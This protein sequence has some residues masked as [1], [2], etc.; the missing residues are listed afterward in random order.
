M[1]KDNG[2]RPQDA[3]LQAIRELSSLAR[4]KG[5]GNTDFGTMH[6]VRVTIS[7]SVICRAYAEELY[8][9]M[10]ATLVINSGNPD[11]TIPFTIQ[12]LYIYLTIILRE[13]IKDV[14]KERTLFSRSDQ[15]VKIPHFYFL[16]L[17]E[18][19]DVVDEQRHVWLQ[20][21]FDSSELDEVYEVWESTYD[22][23]RDTGRRKQ[24]NLDALSAWKE[25]YHV[26]LGEE[27]EKA[28]VYNMSRNLKL[29]ERWGFVNGSALPRGLT[30]E[31][32]FMLFMW[33][34]SK[35]VHPLPDVEPG[36]ALLASLL[37]FSRSTSLLNPYIGYGPENA[38]RILLKEVTLPRGRST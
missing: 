29:L 35:L 2:P 31:L 3:N 15:D 33:M 38:Y 4:L 25:E 9:S 32:S 13:R 37:A 23:D 6:E 36:Q 26:Y 28:F 16:A 21:Y 19:G 18:L 22:H 5:V 17:M 1:S 27:D 10:V 34:E 30:G 20:A 11:A 14:R 8:N 7:P 24:H 12:D